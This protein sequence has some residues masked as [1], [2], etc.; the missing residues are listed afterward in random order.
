M[1]EGSY[2]VAYVPAPVD[3]PEDELVPVYSPQQELLA[4]WPAGQVERNG[5]LRIVRTRRGRIVRAYLRQDDSALLRRLIE[6][7]RRSGYGVA[8]EQQL[9]CGRRLWALRGVRGSK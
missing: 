3:R 4:F 8:F 2:T 5:N 1:A 7:R 6:E 9:P